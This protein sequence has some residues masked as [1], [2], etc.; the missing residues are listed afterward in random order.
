MTPC[1]TSTAAASPLP[2]SVPRLPGARPRRSPAGP[3]HLD[4][5]E[6]LEDGLEDLVLLVGALVEAVGVVGLGRDDSQGGRFPGSIRAFATGRPVLSW[7][8]VLRGAAACRTDLRLRPGTP[9]EGPSTTG[10][11]SCQPQT[12]PGT[13][14][15]LQGCG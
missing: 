9:G 13:T 7:R 3:R 4:R 6:P 12:W 5:G 8:S 10:C 14:P 1:C 2:P 11:P 15:H